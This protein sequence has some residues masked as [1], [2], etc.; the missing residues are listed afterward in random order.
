MD[1]KEDAVQATQEKK[2]EQRSY[3]KR[4]DNSWGSLK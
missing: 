4:L 2:W 1:M 3:S